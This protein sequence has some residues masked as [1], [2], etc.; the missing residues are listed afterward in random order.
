MPD[1]EPE[2]RSVDRL[3]A[4]VTP[5]APPIGFRDAV[6]RRIGASRRAPYEWPLAAALALPSLAFIAWS[7]AVEGVDMALAL[8][9]TLA[10]AAGTQQQAFFSVDGLLVLAFA[11]LGIGALVGSHALVSPE[12]P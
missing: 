3:L 10:L 12:R 5:V 6:M 2:E 4:G 9:N 1:L 7:L 11:L 8:E